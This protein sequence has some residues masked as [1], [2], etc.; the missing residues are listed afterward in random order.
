MKKC[1]LC[2]Y[3]DTCVARIIDESITGCNMEE[4]VNNQIS[5]DELQVEKT[6]TNYI[7]I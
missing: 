7:T 1:E 6:Y 5:K 3:E 4:Y 2:S